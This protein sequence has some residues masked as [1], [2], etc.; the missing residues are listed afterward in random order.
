MTA[1]CFVIKRWSDGFLLSGLWRP[2]G[3]G[4]G[5]RMTDGNA[6]AQR[7]ADRPHLINCQHHDAGQPFAT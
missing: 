3:L 7:V 2:K 1:E 5:V 4:A 6:V